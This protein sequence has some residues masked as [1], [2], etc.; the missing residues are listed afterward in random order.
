MTPQP[1]PGLVE[2]QGPAVMAK[3]KLVGQH[4]ALSQQVQVLAPLTAS[5]TVAAD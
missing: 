5:K 3:T 1:R 2:A 4:F